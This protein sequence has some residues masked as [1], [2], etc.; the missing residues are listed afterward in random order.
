[1]KKILLLGEIPVNC[2]IIED[3]GKC[4][5]VDPGYE[6]DKLVDF[7][8]S[9][10]LEVVGILLTHGHIDHIGALHAYDVPIYM[11]KDEFGIF[12]N[13]HN[14]GFA[15]YGKTH[16]YEVADLNLVLMDEDTEILLNDRA[17]EVIHTP[18][19]TKGCVC[20]K[21]GDD[22]YTGDTLFKGSVGRWDF[23]TGKQK[24]LRHSI[25]D[26]V[27]RFGDSVRIHPAHGESSTIGEEKRSNSYIQFWSISGGLIPPESPQEG[28]FLEAKEAIDQEDFQQGLDQ[29][30]ALEQAGYRHPMLPMYASYARTMIQEKQ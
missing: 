30:M 9:L 13:N 18:G 4:Y 27:D 17:I 12:M 24:V 14:N 8:G 23:P 5:I 2:Y 6:K 10:G 20:F 28:A 22:L 1:M 16:P 3:Q 11:H 19:H 15:Y 25:L 7:V 29:L 21:W 26:L